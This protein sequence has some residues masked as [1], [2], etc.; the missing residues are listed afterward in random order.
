[1]SIPPV[2]FKVKANVSWAGEEEG[3]LGFIENEV[4]EVTSVVDDS[5]LCGRLRRNGAEGIF[6]K[7][8]VVI[9]ESRNNSS[10]NSPANTPSKPST[11][12]RDPLTE[13]R[14]RSAR[15]SGTP[16]ASKYKSLPKR[17]SMGYPES[18][19]HRGEYDYTFD[20]SFD[21]S[22]A[23]I[24][25]ISMRNPRM[26]KPSSPPKMSNSMA[27]YAAEANIPYEE[28][29]A[30]REREIEKFKML[31]EQLHYQIKKIQQLEQES[32]RNSIAV[33]PVDSASPPMKSKQYK[34]KLVLP[35]HYPQEAYDNGLGASNG[36][37]NG[38]NSSPTTPV[39]MHSYSYNDLA[40]MKNRSPYASKAEE[41]TVEASYPVDSYAFD[42][43]R[44]DDVPVKSRS[45]ELLARD[46]SRMSYYENESP[47]VKHLML[48]NN[49]PLNLKSPAYYQKPDLDRI[50]SDESGYYSEDLLSSKK[51]GNTKDDL[52]KKLN[53]VSSYEDQSDEDG[54]PPPPPPPKHSSKEKLLELYKQ[55]ELEDIE[56][57][58]RPNPRN[59]IPYNADDFKMSG[60]TD[61]T[62]PITDEDLLKVSQ[63]A[64]EELKNS[65][66]SLQS[67]VLNLSELSATSAG[68][69]IRHKYDKDLR[70]QEEVRFKRLSIADELNSLRTES[71]DANKKQIIDTIFQDKKS[72]H[73]NIF[74]KLLNKKPDEKVHPLDV[75]PQTEKTDWT[76]LKMD[77]NRM[78]S[79]TTYD[80]Q[81]RTKRVVREDPSLIIKP[82]DYVSDINTN[83]VLGDV[84][85]NDSEPFDIS[86]L[87]H[88]KIDSFINNYTI[89]SDIN[90][91]IFDISIKFNACKASQV[92]CVLLHLCKFSI[93]EENGKILKSKPRLGEVLLKGEA[94]I[95]Q[96]NYLFKKILDALRIPSEIVF[97]FWKKPN[98]YYH[99]EKYILNHCWMSV[100]LNNRFYIIDIL[101]YKKGSIF[102]IR[103]SP[104]NFNEF[105]FLVE[106]IKIISTHIPS[107]IDMQHV[108]PPVD[109]CIAF[110]LP[111]TY[112]GFYRNGLKFRNFNNALT[113][114]KDLDFFEFELEIPID[115]EI[116]TLVKTSKVTTNDLCLAQVYWKENKRIAK[117][118]AILPQDES[119]GVLQI[120]SGPKGMQ[121]YLENVHELSIVVPL[122]H[123]GR[124]KPC[125]FVCRFPTVQS[126]N[127]DLYIKLPQISKIFVKNSY[128]FEILQHP[129]MGLNNISALA[130]KDFR[131]VIE[132]PSGK[133]FK[134]T[135]VDN[136]N[137]FGTYEAN[138]KCAE[139]GLYR[140]LVIGDS[141]NSWYVFAQWECVPGEITD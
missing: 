110:Y 107:I 85:L 91:L 119:I 104:R 140:G 83:E 11:P 129:S 40:S 65:T 81:L 118:K 100:V 57:E 22:D 121:K 71:A 59:K 55:L 73:P 74:R 114:L 86:S 120:F 47:K 26:G 94:S 18:P 39:K 16:V 93:I 136:L 84:D 116:F 98:E 45:R 112:S 88:A 68:S 9:I 64:Q 2:P 13:A 6:P 99:N 123:E 14:L 46:G 5:W 87:P 28:L 122:S 50:N 1:M 133:Y 76:T 105:Y 25:G 92:R 89:A 32:F 29:L 51:Y 67:D 23:D 35:Y 72:R 37:Y 48:S 117:I 128:N 4:I 12:I 34:R 138:I 131:M 58:P 139:V 19:H 111:R 36:V 101:S 115:V 106:P 3:D 75:Q 54:A 79:L 17:K 135:N 77:L 38:S 103:D 63:R 27:K 127:N 42:S 33:Q 137:P 53:K 70:N 43:R 102:N 24:S 125:R 15:Y 82:L 8:Y 30:R 134:L 52:S 66:K 69:F 56:A 49:S 109:Q 141:G 10:T 7:D 78:N 41:V 62:M 61:H 60:Q 95:Y 130:N 90:E 126:Q 31:Q 97:G 80:R 44:N 132:S 21:R 113:K 108:I 124:Y 96:L 20:S